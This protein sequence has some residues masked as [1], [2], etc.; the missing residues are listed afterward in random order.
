MSCQCLLV[1]CMHYCVSTFIW[2]FNVCTVLYWWTA[3]IC[4]ILTFFSFSLYI[5]SLLTNRA[6]LS[7]LWP[8]LWFIVIET[9]SILNFLTFLCIFWFLMFLLNAWGFVNHKDYKARQ[10]KNI[11]VH[12]KVLALVAV[13]FQCEWVSVLIFAFLISECECFNAFN[14]QSQ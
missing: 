11:P 1:W 6:I 5:I 3:W 9:Q 2:L 8:L 4:A 13:A 7:I 10:K 14:V 12:V